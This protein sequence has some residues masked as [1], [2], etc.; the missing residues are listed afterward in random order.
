MRPVGRLVLI[1]WLCQVPLA[2][3]SPATWELVPVDAADD[4]IVAVIGH[5]A[6]PNRVFCATAD[7]VHES[8][9]AGRQWHERLHVPALIA[10]RSLA[11][12]AAEPPTVLAAT[13]HGLYASFDGGSHW[14]RVFQGSDERESTGLY[15]AFHPQRWDTAF[16][17]TH[18]GLF[19]TTDG[20]H[21]WQAVGL[22]FA[23][24]DV[25]HVAFDPKDPER[26]FVL[27]TQGLFAGRPGGG[28]WEKRFGVLNSEE[29][30][31]DAEEPAVEESQPSETGEGTDFLHH[32]SALAV[33]PGEPGTLYLAGSHGVQVSRDEGITWQGLPQTGLPSA[34]VSRL[35]VQRHSPPALYAATSHG[36]ARYTPG[37]ER[38]QPLAF[39]LAASSVNDLAAGETRLWAATAHG[40]YRLEVPPNG[41][42]ESEPPSV[43]ERLANFTH[44]PTIGQV[45]QAAIRYAEVHP[46]KI[47]RW[48]RQAA[49][50]ALLP[51]VDFGFDQNRSHNVHVDEG[52]FPNFQV[53]P[54][55]DRDT[56]WD[57]S[58][59]WELGDLIW[60]DD[61][62][63]IDV[64]SKLMVQLR[65]DLVDEVTRTYFE[66]RRL[67]MALLTKPPTDEPTLIEKELRLRELTA[68][69]DGLTGGAFSE[70]L[71]PPEKAPED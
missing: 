30:A 9:D 60:N 53:F 70:H 71:Q 14:E 48:R 32:L 22:P 43:Q 28:P 11:V 54:T 16:L 2:A 65:N 37:S 50:K 46:D 31:F 23:G 33:D 8:R 5:P 63:S 27:S 64:R 17:G 21:H 19:M 3:A 61:Q 57:C 56:G 45:Q 38:W 51:S 58:V 34:D 1:V 49:L 35:V 66:R 68:L 26:L 62:T 55:K 67:Q 52:T 44:E 24:R 10:I 69:I 20:A 4:H 29:P 42:A 15:V 41:F 6:Q 25:Q 12:N 59:N 40:L 13:N 47:L 39:G 18:G 36:V 7:S